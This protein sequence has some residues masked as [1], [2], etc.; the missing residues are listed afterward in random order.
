MSRRAL[1]VHPRYEVLDQIGRGGEGSVLRVV[2]REE[3]DRRLAAKVLH[4]RGE[5]E[6]TLRAELAILRRALIPGLVRAHDLARSATGELFLVEDLVDGPEARAWLEGAGEVTPPSIPDRVRRLVSVI[7][8]VAITLGGMHAVGIAHG[9]VKPAHVRVDVPSGRITLL[10]WAPPCRASTTS[11]AETARSRRR[12]RRPS[13]REEVRPRLVGIST[14]S[15]RRRSRWSAGIRGPSRRRR[16]P[17][18]GSRR[19]SWI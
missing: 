4:V 18:R 1:I 7:A 6:E 19:A 14:P 15:A 13:A 16:A 9:D 12:S 17:H 5:R 10:I 3:P 8:G 2:D 11:G